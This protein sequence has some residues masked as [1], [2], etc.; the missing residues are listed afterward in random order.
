MSK[1]TETGCRKLM[2]VCCDCDRTVCTATRAESLD[3]NDWY[4]IDAFPPAL[5]Q[6]C[7]YRIE[8]KCKGWYKG[9]PD[10]HRFAPDD[11][12]TPVARVVS[13]RPWKDGQTWEEG[14]KAVREFRE[15][16]YKEAAN[17]D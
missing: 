4:D 12:E 7:E 9:A 1:C 5:D 17:R 6:P 10:E 3:P 8:V 14:F 11:R 2:T 13:W 15:K 16:A